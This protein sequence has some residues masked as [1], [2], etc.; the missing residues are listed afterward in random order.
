[1]KKFLLIIIFTLNINNPLFSKIESRKEAEKFL[2]KYCIE[3]VSNI[4]KSYERQLEAVKKS[5]YETFGR[6]GKWI[7]GLSDVYSKLCK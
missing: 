7:V 6:E 1:M 5:D 2:D 3:L 4:K